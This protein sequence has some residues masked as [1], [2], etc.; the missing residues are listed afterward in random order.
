[1]RTTYFTCVVLIRSLSYTQ[2]QQQT[3]TPIQISPR[4]PVAASSSSVPTMPV[5][6]SLTSASVPSPVILSK[7]PQQKI[8]QPQQQQQ[9]QQVAAPPAA[10]QAATILGLN[11]TS[12]PLAATN[13]LQN[14]QEPLPPTSLDVSAS[15]SQGFSGT[16]M[17][18][19]STATP[20]THQFSSQIS[21]ETA[22]ADAQISQLLDNLKNAPQTLSL[23]KDEKMA[24]FFKSL[25][26][27][28]SANT[29]TPSTPAIALTKDGVPSSSA[30]ASLASDPPA[31]PITTAAKESVASPKGSKV[32]K[33]AGTTGFQASFLNSLASR[34]VSADAGPSQVTV[35]EAAQL[36]PSVSVGGGA[37][38]QIRAL[39]SLPPQTRLIKGPNGQYSIQ[40]IQ[41]IELTHEQQT[42]Q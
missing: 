11:Q 18:M 17:Q 39:Q 19:T 10:A 25:A 31:Q 32:Q 23:G 37:P 21:R 12:K 1:M 38:S 15:T 8:L 16:S 41:T 36:Q 42:V 26:N 2:E 4:S 3:T 40:K 34:R 5:I 14:I 27:E 9:Q 30:L 35:V 7:L 13:L 33:T 20:S 6:S 22:D 28:S 29:S 24:E